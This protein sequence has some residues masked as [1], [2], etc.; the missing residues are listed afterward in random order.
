MDPTK[1]LSVSEVL[2]HEWLKAYVDEDE[3]EGGTDIEERRDQ[4]AQSQVDVGGAE[5]TQ[6][7][8]KKKENLIEAA[9]VSGVPLQEKGADCGQSGGTRTELTELTVGAV[10]LAQTETGVGATNSGE[11]GKGEETIAMTG[12]Q[13]IRASRLYCGEMV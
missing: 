11:R 4:T 9:S 6:A 2:Q 13:V 1:R 7:G 10:R 8:K 5:D 12:T 3:E